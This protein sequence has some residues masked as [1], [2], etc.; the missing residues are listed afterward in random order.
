VGPNSYLSQM[1]FCSHF[2]AL[3]NLDSDVQQTHLCL[4][5]LKARTHIGAMSLGDTI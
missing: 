5:C 1:R 2:V 3:L 4:L